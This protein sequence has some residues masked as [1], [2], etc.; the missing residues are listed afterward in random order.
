MVAVAEATE[1]A[2]HWQAV[3]GLPAAALGEAM[4]GA[5]PWVTAGLVGQ[6]NPVDA[7]FTIIMNRPCSLGSGTCRGSIAASMKGHP[8]R[9]ATIVTLQMQQTARPTSPGVAKLRD[10]R[11]AET[12]PY[13]R[14][15]LL[16]N[17]ALSKPEQTAAVSSQG[18]PFGPARNGA[19][20]HDRLCHQG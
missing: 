12:D 2:Q 18:P 10:L 4:A 9:I 1:R 16:D 6:I 5:V 17:P 13:R 7:D 8:G 3:P 20:Y 19:R 14:R 11:Y 15:T